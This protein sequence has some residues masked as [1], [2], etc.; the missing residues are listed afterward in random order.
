MSTEKNGYIYF[1]INQSMPGL[2]KVGYTTRTLEKRLEELDTTGIP[3]PFQIGAAFAVFDPEKCESSIH[4]KLKE[5]RLKN[6]REFFKIELP[7]AI[8][9]AYPIIKK[10][11]VRSDG[12][13]AL[14][15]LKDSSM[16]IELDAND[17]TILKDLFYDY[18]RNRNY[19]T[20]HFLE[21][22]G[23]EDY[24]LLELE[25]KMLRLAEKGLIVQLQSKHSTESSWK[26]TSFGI[27]FMFENGHVDKDIL[28]D[29]KHFRKNNR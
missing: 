25:Y 27:K 24:H 4:E 23:L 20:R 1:L 22:G 2:V 5:N 26:M 29:D 11:I 16:A 6:D 8:E 13:I 21:L 14:P 3:T 15:Y 17:I 12:P 18:S 19:L 9:L 10:H 7:Q 28:E